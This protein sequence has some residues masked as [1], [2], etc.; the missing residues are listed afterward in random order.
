MMQES[1]RP[2]ANFRVRLIFL[3]DQLNKL[4]TYY[5]PGKMRKAPIETEFR[6]R[7]QRV[8]ILSPNYDPAAY[9]HLNTL[10]YKHQRIPH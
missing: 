1:T 7:I 8:V 10:E 9:H 6:K 4:R 3:G 2:T 5:V